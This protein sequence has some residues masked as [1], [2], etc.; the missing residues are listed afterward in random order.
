MRT[1]PILSVR[2][3]CLSVV[4]ALMVDWHL[5]VKMAWPGPFYSATCCLKLRRKWMGT[6]LQIHLPFIAS[7]LCAISQWDSEYLYFYIQLS[8]RCLSKIT[9]VIAVCT[10]YSTWKAFLK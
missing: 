3:R 6:S 7:I 9:F 10:C 8:F 4:Y 1:K 5:K 2:A